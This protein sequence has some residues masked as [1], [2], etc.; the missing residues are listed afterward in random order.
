[1]V[2]PVTVVFVRSQTLAHLNRKL[3]ELQPKHAA[4]EQV[5][6]LLQRLQE[7]QAVFQELVRSGG[8]WS[9]RLNILSDVT[10]EGVWFTELM[11][12]RGERLLIQG[13]AIGEGGAEMMRVGRLVQDLKANADFSKVVKDIQIESIKRETDRELEIVRFTLACTLVGDSKP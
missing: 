12:E 3:A 10:P 13:A 8:E 1:M 11:L 9:K 4:V 6:R 7:Q 5:R 2:I